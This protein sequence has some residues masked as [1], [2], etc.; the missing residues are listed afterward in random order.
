MKDKNRYTETWD[1]LN[2][3]YQK[4]NNGKEE[5]ILDDHDITIDKDSINNTFR[6]PVNRRQLSVNS[7]ANSMLNNSKKVYGSNMRSRLSK[8]PKHNLSLGYIDKKNSGFKFYPKKNRIF[9]TTFK[10]TKFAV[11]KRLSIS[12]SRLFKFTANYPS[13]DVSDSGHLKPYILN[14]NKNR[15]RYLL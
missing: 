11:K 9:K 2:R 5:D 1:T 3:S 10:C 12:P 7:S 15:A 6:T 14:H 13:E 4:H 8:S